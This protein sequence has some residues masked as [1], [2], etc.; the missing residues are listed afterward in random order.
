MGFQLHLHRVSGRDVIVDNVA[1]A[2]I[3]H[4]RDGRVKTYAGHV[5]EIVMEKDGVR[6]T[7]LDDADAFFAEKTGV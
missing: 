3:A 5:H 6:Q 1:Q 2:I 4:V 7:F